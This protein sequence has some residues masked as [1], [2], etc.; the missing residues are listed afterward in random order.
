MAQTHEARTEIFVWAFQ[1]LSKEEQRAVVNR[2]LEEPQ[3]REDI[4]DVM[5]IRQRSGEQPRP[6]REYLNNRQKQLDED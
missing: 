1:S 4:L 5:T 3:F 6:F 2:L